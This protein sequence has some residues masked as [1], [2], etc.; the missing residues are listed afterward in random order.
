MQAKTFL[1]IREKNLFIN[2]NVLNESN[3][4]FEISSIILFKPYMKMW[5]LFYDHDRKDLRLI[6][7]DVYTCF[8]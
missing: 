6:L 5:R 3:I 7:L 2:I 4:F 8:I 1:K